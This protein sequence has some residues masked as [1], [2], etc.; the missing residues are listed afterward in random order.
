MQ[1]TRTHKER[2]KTLFIAL[3]AVSAVVLG[4]L[5]GLFELPIRA[6]GPEPEG[7]SGVVRPWD[8]AGQIL[9]AAWPSAAMATIAPE[10]FQGHQMDAQE[11]SP[12]NEGLGTL[13]ALF[14]G[15]LG[16]ALGSSGPSV[17]VTRAEWEAALLERGVFFQYDV[18][19]PAAVFARWFGTEVGGAQGPMSA[20]ALSVGQEAVYLYYMGR[21]GVPYRSAT[22][23]RPEG[24]REVL[25]NLV[26]NG[27]RFGFFLPQT[28]MDP[29]AVLLASHSGI[30]TVWG[31]NAVG[32]VYAHGDAFLEALGLTPALIRYFDEG[33]TRT[34]V[35]GGATLWIHENGLLTY[36]CQCENP[37]L[38]AEAF[39]EGDLTQAIEAA[40]RVVEVLHLVSGE[41]ELWL[42]DWSY[43]EGAF[44]LVFGYY[45]GG[46]PV[47]MSAPAATVQ[48]VEGTVREVT[49]F[50][51][52]FYKTGFYG[53]VMPEVQAM[54]AAGGAIRLAYTAVD[55]DVAP[56]AVELRARWLLGPAGEVSHG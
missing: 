13:Y 48:L 53:P 54:A 31:M 47:W 20:L 25:E 38:S 33:G 21:A 12:A 52:A 19:L 50:A 43:E 3:L 16:E 42:T 6:G 11:G 39:G 44:L 46:V 5:T 23:V 30:P 7:E 27:A 28:E 51:R 2:I 17:A 10:T 45:L 37:R 22:A 35:E 9:P 4:S 36:H 24:L 40:R 34:I 49:L 55:F 41:A 32:S 8:R 29:D 1:L 15:H 18:E 56:E 26:P 14:S